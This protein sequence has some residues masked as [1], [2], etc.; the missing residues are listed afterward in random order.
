MIPAN[1]LNTAIRSFL[2]PRNA[3]RKKKGGQFGY[4]RAIRANLRFNSRKAGPLSSVHSGCKEV[5]RQISLCFPED[6][7]ISR[8][9]TVRAEIITELI[10]KR[11]GPVI[12]KTFLLELIAFRSIP[13]ICPARGVKPENYRKR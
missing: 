7:L 10:L 2:V 4:P 12:F 8:D 11:A 6:P 3:I 13:V 5:S 9:F 1:R